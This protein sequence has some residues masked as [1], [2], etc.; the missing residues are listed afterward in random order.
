MTKITFIS[1]RYKKNGKCNA[2]NLCSILEIQKPEVI[3]LEALEA[4]YSQFERINFSSFGIY[5]HKLEIEAL[6]KLSAH[7]SFKYVPVLDN[8]ITNLFDK[9]Y[10]SIPVNNELD[11]ML[12]EFSKLECLEGFEFLNSAR[13][14]ALHSKMRDFENSLLQDEEFLKT[15]DVKLEEYE[16]S[17][18][19]NIYSFCKFNSFEKGVYMCGSAHRESLIKK[20]ELFECKEKLGIKWEVFGD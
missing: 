3:F 11:A 14:M 7:F 4:T 13:G 2:D 1:T 8:E 18:I 15:Y 19:Q 10:N 5:H 16:N 20:F 9:K 12:L 17:M 6:Q